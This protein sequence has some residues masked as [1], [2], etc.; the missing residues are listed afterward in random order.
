M[1]YCV[2][3]FSHTGFKGQ[4]KSY[5]QPF[6]I[7]NEVHEYTAVLPRLPDSTILNMS[8]N[9]NIRASVNPAKMRK[10]FY[11]LKDR[12]HFDYAS[13]T[14]SGENMAVIEGSSLVENAPE[15]TSSSESS[16]PKKWTTSEKRNG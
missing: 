3:H 8:Y 2:P 4:M 15:Q 13:I 1:L 5:R 6:A 11:I 16:N 14:F 9:F 12:G 7:Y 10:T